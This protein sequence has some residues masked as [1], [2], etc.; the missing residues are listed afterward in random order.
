MSLA[1]ALHAKG[2][3]P[4][5]SLPPPSPL[6]MRAQP[7]TALLLALSA[8]S[9]LSTSEAAPQF[10]TIPPGLPPV[11]APPENP[12][13]PD[14]VLLGQALF[15]EEQ[16]SASG[17][18][19]CGTCHR[20]EAGGADPRSATHPG[21]DGVF[22]S[23]DDVLGSPGVIRQ[24]ANGTY[25]PDAVFGLQPQ[26]TARRAPS[27]VN[28][29]LFAQ[30]MWDGAAE[31][32]LLD[33][34][35]GQSLAA[36]GAALE[37][38]AAGP[39]LSAI[40]MAHTSEDWGAIAQRVAGAVPLALASNLPS[41][42][43]QFVAGQSYPTLFA[44]A[45]GSAEVTPAR[46]L[47][48]LASYQRTLLSDQSRWDDF[49]AGDATALNA[50]EIKGRD[51]FFGAANCSECHSGQ[52]LADGLFHDIGV[53][54]DAE[55]LGRGGVTGL[56]EDEGRFRTPSLRNVEL[57]A[58]YFHNGG[59]A[60]LGDVLVFYDD[61][62]DFEADPLIQELNLSP[63]QRLALVAF[64]R[65]FTD[66]RVAAGL[67]PFDRPTLFSESALVAAPA[68]AGSAGTGGAV[69]QFLAVEPAYVG[70]T[71]FSLGARQLSAGAWTWLAFDASPATPP[72][73]L[74]GA[75]VHLALSPAFVLLPWMPGA[76]MLPV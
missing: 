67:P 31:G 35:S 55:D 71:Q 48:A 42:L 61:G 3:D 54:P 58:P 29:A 56:P 40:E 36:A 16:L 47:F 76:A 64:L 50:Q 13:E 66:P 1:R 32:A 23:A 46:I 70:Q 30:L 20:P 44:Q 28:A 57:R 72:V 26:V 8:L 15:W 59:A 51:L 24:Q 49:L 39:P 25:E 43:A 41:A 14:K 75:D 10:E 6:R 65:T 18:M 5:P 11:V 60:S 12:V 33:P 38:Q 7:P 21:L 73:Q 9:G 69:P 37:I 52:L 17:S 68:G 19:A 4:C 27:V 62:G 34:L 53:R 22:G 45:F 2:A 63:S 74:G